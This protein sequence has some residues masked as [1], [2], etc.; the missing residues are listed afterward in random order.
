ML[1]HLPKTNVKMLKEENTTE[2]CKKSNKK[3]YEINEI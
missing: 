3:P 2:I 1:N